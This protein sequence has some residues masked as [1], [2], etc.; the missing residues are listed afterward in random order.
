M[1]RPIRFPIVH[2]R[3]VPFYPVVSLTPELKRMFREIR[4]LD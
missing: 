4:M 1:Y 3:E 2:R